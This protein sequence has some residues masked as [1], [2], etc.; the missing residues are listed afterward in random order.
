MRS[1]KRLCVF[2]VQLQFRLQLNEC[3]SIARISKIPIIR[4]IIIPRTIYY[5]SHVEHAR[6]D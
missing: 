6:I 4:K 1:F 5:G 2:A 3:E